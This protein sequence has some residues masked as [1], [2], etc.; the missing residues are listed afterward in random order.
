ME[1]HIKV[2]DSVP[3]KNS[4]APKVKIL[5]RSLHLVITFAKLSANWNLIKLLQIH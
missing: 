4:L 3:G 2:K 5:K 1:N